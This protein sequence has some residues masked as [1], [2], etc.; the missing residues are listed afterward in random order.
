MARLADGIDRHAYGRPLAEGA[1]QSDVVGA[2]RAVVSGG[3]VCVRTA[4]PWNGGRTICPRCGLA[5]EDAE[6]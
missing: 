3:G 2:L 5:A 6:H 4:R 1:L